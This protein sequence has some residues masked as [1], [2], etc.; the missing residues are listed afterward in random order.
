[1]ECGD[2]GSLEWTLEWTME[3]TRGS[4]EKKKMEKM[5]RW[6][7][8]EERIRKEGGKGWRYEAAKG[9][10]TGAECTYSFQ[11]MLLWERCLS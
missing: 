7:P 1:M 8:S 11:R 9:D 5:N 4:M 2:C 10:E 6:D 3:G